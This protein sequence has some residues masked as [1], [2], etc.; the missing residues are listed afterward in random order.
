MVWSQQI[1]ATRPAGLYCELRTPDA[2]TWLSE[3]PSGRSIR[4][5]SKPDRPPATRPTR[6][7]ISQSARPSV[8]FRDLHVNWEWSTRSIVH[9]IDFVV[10]RDRTRAHDPGIMNAGLPPQG[11]TRR[12]VTSF[13]GSDG[14]RESTRR[15]VVCRSAALR[16]FAH[17][18][19]GDVMQMV[20]DGHTHFC[21]RRRKVLSRIFTAAVPAQNADGAAV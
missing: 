15:S 14:G 13:K 20:H 12:A 19:F 9:V 18:R 4:S 6:R 8:S 7:Q 5:T 2:P 10:E 21:Q 3:G 16:L 17:N 1:R 11:L